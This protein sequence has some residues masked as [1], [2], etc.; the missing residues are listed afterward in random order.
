MLPVTSNGD[1]E[2][3]NLRVPKK[4][5][6]R[7]AQNLRV[8]PL[9]G[10]GH[11]HGIDGNNNNNNGHGKDILG[12]K[13]EFGLD[14]EKAKGLLMQAGA[15]DHRAKKY[16]EAALRKGWSEAEMLEE[17]QWWLAYCDSPKGHDVNKPWALAGARI[18]ENKPVSDAVKQAIRDAQAEAE[19]MAQ[20]VGVGV[21]AVEEEESPAEVAWNDIKFQLSLQMTRA[22]FDT[23]IHPTKGVSLED[24]VMTVAVQSAQ[25]V[26]W[27]TH[28]LGV[29][30]DR[31]IKR[32]GYEQV[33]YIIEGGV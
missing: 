1:G 20:G 21:N 28:R 24:G 15:Y 26:E 17:L 29:V 8:P 19:A 2:A 5:E 11:V 12:E 16:V 4:F 13:L 23:W 18:A 7:E 33:E 30:I 32:M 3:Q 10:H 6:R 9:H 27:L 31:T 14:A 25:A 22:T